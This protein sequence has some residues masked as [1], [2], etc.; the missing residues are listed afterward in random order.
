VPKEQGEFVVVARELNTERPFKY[1]QHLSVY[2]IGHLPRRWFILLATV[3]T[4][5]GVAGA[6]KLLLGRKG[7]A[8]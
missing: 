1:E 6:V 7:K 2:R 5:V 8:P 4:L 3:G